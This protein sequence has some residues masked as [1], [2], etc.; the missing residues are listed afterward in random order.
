MISAYIHLLHA[1]FHFF[2]P[3]DQN[4]KN[5]FKCKSELVLDG[6][7]LPD[8]EMVGGSIHVTTRPKAKSFFEIDSVGVRDKDVWV[9]D[10]AL[11]NAFP[12]SIIPNSWLGPVTV[13]CQS[14]HS[15]REQVRG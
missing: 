5:N 1:L 11:K 2:A 12:L 7:L 4:F 14:L 6:C 8:L 15:S 9:V 3:F 10:G 13:T